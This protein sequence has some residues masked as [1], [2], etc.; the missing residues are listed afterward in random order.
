MKRMIILAAISLLLFCFSSQA[1]AFGKWKAGKK[2]FKQNCVTC[3]KRGGTAPKIKMPDYTQ[4]EWIK[5]VRDNTSP[6][7]ESTLEKITPD[8]RQDLMQ[9]LLKYAKPDPP[10]ILSCA[11]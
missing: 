10:T 1:M 2:V 3:H 4:T 7:H 5:F 6:R 9:Y 8:S 11:G